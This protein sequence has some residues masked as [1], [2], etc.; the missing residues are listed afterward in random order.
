[1]NMDIYFI[2]FWVILGVAII[3]FFNVYI[4]LIRAKRINCRILKEY[5][6]SWEVVKTKKIGLNKEDFTYDGCKYTINTKKVVFKKRRGLELNFES[7]KSEPIHFVPYKKAK[8]G[9]VFES[10]VKSKVIT[11]LLKGEL[12]KY[13]VIII[14]SLIVVIVG[15]SAYSI[16][17]TNNMNKE[18]L[19]YA[20]LFANYTRGVVIG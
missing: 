14:I 11:K 16:Y 9:K 5:G 8:D 17:T 1:M 7:G 3:V 6:D 20:E 19:E 4:L 10:L 15:I 2:I 12:D 13:Y 18:I